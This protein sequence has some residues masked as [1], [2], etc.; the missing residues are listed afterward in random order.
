MAKCNE[1]GK[2]E[3]KR[4]SQFASSHYRLKFKKISNIY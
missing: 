3:N 2:N 4:P 1:K